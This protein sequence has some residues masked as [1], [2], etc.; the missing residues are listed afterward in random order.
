MFAFQLFFGQLV[1]GNL[2]FEVRGPLLDLG[3]QRAVDIGQALRHLV[4][5]TFEDTEFVA[6]GD[7]NTPTHVTGADPRRG[8]RQVKDRAR[9]RSR[10]PQRYQDDNH[11]RTNQRQGRQVAQHDQG[12]NCFPSI[13]LDHHPPVRRVNM[14]RR[15]HDRDPAIIGNGTEQSLEPAQRPHRQ[16][17]LVFLR[18]H[19]MKPGR[20]I[21][22]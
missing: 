5:R 15:R 14:P 18:H 7:R 8:L 17:F 1:L 6:R 2:A 12:I 22:P 4:E 13:D 20:R 19:P 9:D 3:F 21:M 16:V 10:Q 11:H